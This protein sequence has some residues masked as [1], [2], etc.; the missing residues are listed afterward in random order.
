MTL[1]PAATEVGLAVL[2]AT[3]S[4]CVARATTSEAVA[5]LFAVLGSVIDE[6]TF[7]VSL[8]AVPGAVPAVTFTVYVIVPGAPGARLGSVQV[9]VATVHVQPAARQ[10][11]RVV[12]AGSVSVRL[13]VVA[14]LGPPLVTTCV[15]V[16]TLPA[17]TGT[18]AAVFVTDRSAESMTYVPTVTA[19]LPVFGSPVVELTVSVSERFVPWAIVDGT[20]TTRVK[21]VVVVLAARF[22][23][24]VQVKVAK[25][26][27]HPAGPVNELAVVP[28]GR[29]STTF[30]VVAACGPAFVTVCV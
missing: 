13:T 28:V 16:M 2:V 8:M 29:V 12:F 26:Q 30:G 21:A 11:D 23:P 19:L 24:S 7:A 27:V 6:V 22:V 10:R 5:V 25:V 9:K 4:A 20:D 14:V 18:G 15:Y 1:L 17:C 3:R